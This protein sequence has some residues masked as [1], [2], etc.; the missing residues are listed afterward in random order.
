ME[1]EQNAGAV[2]ACGNIFDVIVV[3][4]GPAGLLCGLALAELGLDT[5]VCGKLPTAA[6]G[7]EDTRTAALLEPSL[8]LLDN[9]GIWPALAPECAPLSAIRIVDAMGRLPRAPEVLFAAH[10]LGLDHVGWNVPNMA[11]VSCLV[12]KLRKYPACTAIFDQDITDV[13]PGSE[14]VEI[15]FGDGRRFKGRLVV[16]ADGQRS[17]CRTAAGIAVRRWRYTQAAIVAN[18]RHGRAHKGVSTEFHRPAGPFTVVPLQDHRSSLVWVEGQSRAA[19]LAKLDEPAFCA[20]MEEHLQGLLGTIQAVGARRCFPLAGVVAERSA[21]GRI[22]LVG[23]SAHAFPPIGAQGLNLTFRDVAWLAACVEEGLSGHDGTRGGLQGCDVETLLDT[24]NA[25]RRTDVASRVM[26]VDSLNR[27]LTSA[28]APVGL[29]R[30]AVLHAANAFGPF[31][32]FLMQAGMSG[33]GERPPLMHRLCDRDQAQ[34]ARMHVP[35]T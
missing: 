32:R 19:D 29:M 1:L 9:L 33:T 6:G 11:L 20:L 3:G 25:R 14:S 24:F 23:E 4:A 17:I 16:G 10:E 27:S 7:V 26:A 21:S 31:R 35:V 5:L 12:D 30:G 22:A 15:A 28:L 2:D 8:A 18:F 34:H 13:L